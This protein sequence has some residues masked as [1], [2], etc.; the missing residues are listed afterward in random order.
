VP[1]RFSITARFT[2][3]WS[4]PWSFVEGVTHDIDR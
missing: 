2:R 4:A 3:E 1:A